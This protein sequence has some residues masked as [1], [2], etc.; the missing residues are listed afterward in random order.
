LDQES[1]WIRRHAGEYDVVFW[2]VY[3]G[4][5][6]DD[7]GRHDVTRDAN[8]TIIRVK[9]S[10]KYVNADGRAV[11]NVSMSA[12]GWFGI[13][14]PAHDFLDK[15]SHFFVFVKSVVVSWVSGPTNDGI[16]RLSGGY[17]LLQLE[18]KRIVNDTLRDVGTP[19]VVVVLPSRYNYES[20]GVAVQ[21]SR[22]DWTDGGIAS[23][24]DVYPFLSKECF[25]VKDGHLNERGAESVARVLAVNT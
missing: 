20:V 15:H 10:T 6:I 23:V 8:G 13:I 7:V 16:Y 22:K 9:D 19:V 5:D 24:I 4:N 11:H 18:G 17:S 1:V 21:N 14:K 2:L 12:G 25:F 3:V